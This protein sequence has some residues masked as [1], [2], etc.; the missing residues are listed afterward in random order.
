[1]FAKDPD[2]PALLGERFDLLVV[3]VA[4]VRRDRLHAGVRGDDRVFRLSQQ[5]PEPRRVDVRNIDDDPEPV[6]LV[7]KFPA[8][9]GQSRLRQAAT[10]GDP[11]GEDGRAAP[12]RRET[13]QPGLG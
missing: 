6:A 9:L 1:M 7:D 4:H 13:T 10:E 5:V 11:V 12:G 8:D 2:G 3:E